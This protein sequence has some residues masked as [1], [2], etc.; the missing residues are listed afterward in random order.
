MN[1]TI[2]LQRFTNTF[3]DLNINKQCLCIDQSLLQLL[4][5]LLNTSSIGLYF[6]IIF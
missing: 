4:E 1:Y 5:L 6:D 3:Y 2:F